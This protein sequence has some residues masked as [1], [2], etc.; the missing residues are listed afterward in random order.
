MTGLASNRVDADTRLRAALASGAAAERFER[1]AAGLGGPSDLLENF[2]KYLPRA[3]VQRAVLA[4]DAGFVSK[5]DVRGL[6]NAI[7]ELGGGRKLVNQVLDLSVGLTNVAGKGQA[8][9]AGQEL[10][11]VHAR[12]EADAE[13]VAMLVRNAFVIASE[14]PAPTAL[15]RWYEGK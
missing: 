9:Q 14:A 2:D 10:A 7:V 6:G 5:V 12:D 13:R 3:P 8:V 15:Y 11:I 4:Q 1:M